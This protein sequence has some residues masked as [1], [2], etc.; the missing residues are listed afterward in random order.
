MVPVH[1][2]EDHL[3]YVLF[4]HNFYTHVNFLVKIVSYIHIPFVIIS[5]IPQSVLFPW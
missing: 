3:K 2:H 4:I 5:N 1:K